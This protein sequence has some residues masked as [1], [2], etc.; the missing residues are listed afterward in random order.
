MK[1]QSYN[2]NEAFTSRVYATP[3]HEIIEVLI[4]PSEDPVRRDTEAPCA[5]HVLRQAPQALQGAVQLVQFA[6]QSVNAVG[7]LCLEG[8]LER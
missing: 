1:Y 3:T 5:H 8:G 6:G 4:A 7:E 2:I